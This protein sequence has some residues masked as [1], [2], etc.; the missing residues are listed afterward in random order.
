MAIDTKTNKRGTSG[1]RQVN[2]S[3]QTKKYKIAMSVDLLYASVGGRRKN[4][5]MPFP[6]NF[7]GGDMAGRLLKLCEL[8]PSDA[9]VT[10][11]IAVEKLRK[12]SVREAKRRADI[13]FKSLEAA[14][15]DHNKRRRAN[16][17]AWLDTD[18]PRQLADAIAYLQRVGA[19]TLPKETYVDNYGT[20]L[21]SSNELDEVVNQLLGMKLTN[22]RR[23]KLAKR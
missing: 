17:M 19:K 16:L 6:E 5:K 22:T 20:E 8:V 18:G 15:S 3:R 11:D 9:F 1:N 10:A 23:R 14:D 12:V 7:G 2:R 21:K 4:S 13:Y